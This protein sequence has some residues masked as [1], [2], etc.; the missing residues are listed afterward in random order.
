M[1]DQN[2]VEKDQS[3]PVE[4]G[5]ENKRIDRRTFLKFVGIAGGVAVTGACAPTSGPPASSQ[6]ASKP[7][8][9]AKPAAPPAGGAAAPAQAPAQAPAA[10]SGAPAASSKPSGGEIVIGLVHPLTGATAY[11]GNLVNNACI[12]R[13]DE[14]NAAGG[15]KSMGG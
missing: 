14:L 7:A 3:E 9:P 12:M 2:R 1:S 11:E 13:L 10:S 5:E 8:E 4:T 15:I 6:P